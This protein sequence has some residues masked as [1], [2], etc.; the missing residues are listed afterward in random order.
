MTELS[1]GSV[2]STSNQMTLKIGN[3]FEEDQVFIDPSPTA[4]NS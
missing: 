4:K 3:L 1:P 2:D